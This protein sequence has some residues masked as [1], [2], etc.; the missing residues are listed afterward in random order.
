MSL[1][2]GERAP[3]FLAT[4]RAAIGVAN[5]FLCGLAGNLTASAMSQPG[6]YVRHIQIAVRA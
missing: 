3:K 1:A 2:G 5:L 4:A 6:A